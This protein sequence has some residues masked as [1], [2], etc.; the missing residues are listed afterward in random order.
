MIAN[1]DNIHEIY[2]IFIKKESYALRYI[3]LFQTL[4]AIQ[5]AQPHENGEA[6]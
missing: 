2:N 5:D 3:T 6:T 1:L 4:S